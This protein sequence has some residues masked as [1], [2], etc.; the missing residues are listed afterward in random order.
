MT[1][2]ERYARGLI[3]LE[4]KPMIWSMNGY[5]GR[6]NKE[7]EVKGRVVVVNG[8]VVRRIRPKSAANACLAHSAS[9]IFRT[10]SLYNVI[11]S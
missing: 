9:D 6:E 5:K 2:T 10:Q 11:L 1:G 3:I 8:S 4:K 7:V